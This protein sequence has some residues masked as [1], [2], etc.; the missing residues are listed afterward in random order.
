MIGL[1]G[2]RIN[3]LFQSTHP[4]GVRQIA[5]PV[6]T[7]D[8]LEFQSTHPC[9]VRPFFSWYSGASWLSFNPRTPAGCDFS[10]LVIAISVGVFQSTHPCGV[11]LFS[12]RLI[13]ADLKFQSTH[14]CGV[15]RGARSP[16][17]AWL[18]FNPRTPAG[19]DASLS[20]AWISVWAFQSTH[21]CGVRQ[22]PLFSR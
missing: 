4:C 19:C 10:V 8:R 14:P 21:P 2:K 13:P 20:M 15:R 9:G 11:R 1:F 18:S 17:P 16:W 6:L 7:P 12:M 5:V 3:L 22:G